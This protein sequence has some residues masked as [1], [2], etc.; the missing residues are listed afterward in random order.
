MWKSFVVVHQ[1]LAVP[2]HPFV[3]FATGSGREGAASSRS[4]RS[5]VVIRRATALDLDDDRIVRRRGLKVS[6]SG[7]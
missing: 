4:R 2:H 1:E 5:P 3:K 7:N 6:V